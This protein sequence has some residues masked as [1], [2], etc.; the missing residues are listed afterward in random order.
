MKILFVVGSLER[1]GAQLRTLEVCRALRRQYP[2]Q[3]DFCVLGRGPIQLQT[4]IEDI[5]GN[6]H[7]V[8]VRSPHFIARFSELL[9]RGRYD[10]LNSFPWL[11]S[12]AIAGLARRHHVPTRIVSI[13]NSLGNSG[14]LIFNLPCTWL[15][16]T[17]IKRNATHVVAVSRSALD[18][19]FPPPWQS[20]CD[21]RVIYNG[22]TLSPFQGPDERH[23]VRE[24]FGWPCDSQI[25][26]NVARFSP[27]KNHRVVLGTTHLARKSRRGIRLLLVGDGRLH[28]EI[29][30]LIDHYG[31]RGKC[32]VAGV[33]RDVPR[34]LLAA[35]VFLFPSRWEGLPGALLEALA[36]GLPA[37]TSDIPSVKEIA[38]YFHSRILMAPPNN[39]ER[40]ARH[41]L[42]ALDM[43]VDRSLG[44]EQFARTPFL[45]ENVVRS[46]SILYGLA[47][48]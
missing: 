40:L 42:T 33:R 26:I 1:A 15:T 24:E 2:I 29:V 46:Y 12:G 7:L 45:L 5:G 34:L 31:L 28:N 37:V 10:C 41:T 22:L 21:C 32:V 23:E 36:A 47:E 38:E 11:F 9:R 20:R 16:R 6:I 14:R 17:L 44:Q 19:A 13:R 27:Q 25:V 3:C 48:T 4:E 18:S 8:Y 43:P 30:R 35:D 39:A